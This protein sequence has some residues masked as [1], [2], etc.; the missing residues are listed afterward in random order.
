MIK[1]FRKIRQKLLSENKFSK[2]LIYA[3]G[4]IVL[5]V[6]GILIALQINNWNENKKQIIIQNKI[7]LQIQS[8]LQKDTIDI[9]ESIQFYKEKNERLENI[10]LRKIPISYYQSLNQENY[11]DCK[12]CKNDVT[13]FWTFK[14]HN[15]GYSQLKSFNTNLNEPLD[16]L[17]VKID[18]F[19]YESEQYIKF[20]NEILR[21]L[22][23]QNIK[24]YVQYDWFIDWS[25]SGNKKFIK[26][27]VK[28]IFESKD[29]RIKSAQFLTFSR[30]QLHR[31]KHYKSEATEILKLIDIKLKK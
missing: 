18:Q 10:I 4:E 11:G 17:L 25:V 31:I 19:Y 2:Y 26:D 12:E 29:Y 8:D 14:N 23:N 21:S 9:V 20:S 22:M 15:K 3:I 6:L 13:Y 27:Y 24:S 28:Y 30:N 7:L 1:F 16:S 5:V